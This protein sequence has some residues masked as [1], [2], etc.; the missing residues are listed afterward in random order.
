MISELTDEIITDKRA[1]E[2]KL[3]AQ[4]SQIDEDLSATSAPIRTA[5]IPVEA[6]PL[7]RAEQLKAKQA[8]VEKFETAYGKVDKST[9]EVLEDL[10]D[11]E[12]DG[13]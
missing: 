11:S 2:A 12:L 4:K 10:I 1:K 6:K 3:R 13:V 9:G 7:S 8:K 5:G